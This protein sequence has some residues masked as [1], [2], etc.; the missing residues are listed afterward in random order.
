MLLEI[1]D[2]P[3]KLPLA[4]EVYEAIQPLF[5]RALGIY[6]FSNY[7]VA[8]DESFK[9]RKVFF[10]RF[11]YD[12]ISMFGLH[13]F[14]IELQTLEMLLRRVYRA[15]S[16]NFAAGTVRLRRVEDVEPAF[17]EEEF[18][19]ALEIQKKD[20]SRLNKLMLSVH[21]ERIQRNTSGAL[22]ADDSIAPSNK[23]AD[24]EDVTED[25]DLFSGLLGNQDEN[26]LEVKARKREE[27]K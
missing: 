10:A 16:H 13:L 9:G 5:Q 21:D 6:Y 7:Y 17:S 26:I 27:K 12:L 2:Q 1:V 25:R 19:E 24:E 22:G 15:V 23:E 8:R 14:Y 4:L 18:N 3:T 20:E 11:V